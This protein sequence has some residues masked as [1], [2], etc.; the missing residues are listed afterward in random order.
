[1]YSDLFIRHLSVIQILKCSFLRKSNFKVLTH[2]TDDTDRGSAILSFSTAI[3]N[4]RPSGATNRV[5]FYNNSN[6]ST[7]TCA[8][9][10]NLGQVY[11]RLLGLDWTFS[12]QIVAAMNSSFLLRRY[13]ANSSSTTAGNDDQI[14]PSDVL[15][16][17]KKRGACE[18]ITL[19]FSLPLCSSVFRRIILCSWRHKPYTCTTWYLV[20]MV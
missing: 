6:R 5:R 9:I 4:Q 12:N 14:K 10:Q 20:P 8:E 13:R 7:R 16:K 3:I 15:I 2:A 11:S 19:S 18:L 17:Q 1:M